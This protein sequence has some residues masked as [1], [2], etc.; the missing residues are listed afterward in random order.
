MQESLV[1]LFSNPGF[2]PHGMCYL[3]QPGTLW[4]NVGSDGL[5][6]AAYY[7]I[8]FSLY[9]LVRERRAEIPYPGVFLMFA[10][11]IFL[12][13]T[14]HVME[15]WAVWQPN[16]RMA[17]ALKAVTGIVSV[18]T[19]VALFQIMPKAMLLRGPQQLQ[20]EVR[21]RTAELARLNEQLSAQIGGRDRAEAQLRE[22]DQRKDE[23]LATLAH[24]L[25][26]PLAPIRHAI[27]VLGVSAATAQQQHWA[28][29]V[30]DRQAGRMALLLDDLLEV[31][32]ITRGK[33]SLKKER[34]SV[35]A[36]VASA[37]ET[38]GPAIEAKALVLEV[39]VPDERIELEA[40]P[41][42]LSQALSNL[43]TNATKFT[44]RGGRIRL[45]VSKP[46]EGLV[47]EVSD[48]GIGFEPSRAS[49]LF[50]MFSQGDLAAEGADGGLGIGLAL[51]KG[52][53]HLHGGSVHAQSPG[54][55][56][57][58]T[59]TIRLPSSLL[60]PDSPSAGTST[61]AIPPAKP[62][63]PARVLIVDDNRDAAG[64]LGLLLEFAGHHV[65]IAHSGGEALVLGRQVQPDIVLLDIGMPD[66]SGYEVAR[67]A[68]HEPWGMRA[69]LVALTGWGQVADKQRARDAGF[70]RHLT[71]P[72]DADLVD[73]LV[74][75][76][77]ASARA[78][79]T[80]RVLPVAVVT[81]R[82]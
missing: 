30:I 6:A 2:M 67:A 53:V 22:R 29:E 51:V 19:M 48:T 68:R 16:Y 64:S 56:H 9:Y 35:A 57:G 74:R 36:L 38:V 4:L 27:K 10:A 21:T 17:G 5:I 82:T 3:W 41:L 54:E 31:S 58:A 66:L 73:R 43:L 26:N 40:D 13:G 50:E 78:D 79:G 61:A 12:C 42:R 1:W 76:S 32:R 70:D 46:S 20:E 18:A 11:F 71:K 52:L 77:V 7:A 81:T 33:L 39:A 23:F 44:P 45:A 65:T 59:F 75:E 14:T 37:V 8:P 28:R 47:I 63:G 15:I 25:R 62:G 49:M 55:G 34:V 60:L 80:P 72:V 69:F 24:E